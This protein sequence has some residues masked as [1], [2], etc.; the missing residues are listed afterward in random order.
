MARVL[1]V[2]DDPDILTLLSK[3]LSM[4]GHA[5]FK[6]ENAIRAMDYLNSSHFDLLIS[7]AKMP[8][9]TGFELVRMIKGNKK[10]QDMAIAMLTGLREKKDIEQA[11]KAGVDDYIVKPIEPAVLLEKIDALFDK[12]PP[13]N[14]EHFHISENSHLARSQMRQDT[15]IVSFDEFHVD[16]LSPI[17]LQPQSTIQLRGML[18][19]SLDIEDVSVTVNTCVKQGKHYY[20]K[21][22]FTNIR[23]S[24]QKKIR[25]WINS[26][27]FSGAKKGRVA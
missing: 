10:F 1:I 11:I 20:V 27:S 9:F 4:Q 7:D 23:E 19:T 3:I 22:A 16:F 18:F 14:L 5:V 6:A 13:Q 12:K 8:Q 24:H 17:Q 15:R 26:H 21:A 25:S 2:D